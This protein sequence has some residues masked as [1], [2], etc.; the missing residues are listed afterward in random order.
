MHRTFIEENDGHVCLNS[1]PLLRRD[2]DEYSFGHEPGFWFL[3][4][5]EITFD[6]IPIN[7]IESSECLTRK[8]I[9]KSKEKKAAFDEANAAKFLYEL[10]SRTDAGKIMKIEE[11][12]KAR[13]L[14]DTGLGNGA[15]EI[16][17]ILMNGKELDSWLQ[18]Q[19]SLKRVR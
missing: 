17:E 6:F 14:K 4:M 15:K 5:D 16:I 11:R 2:A 18:R 3:N 9:S 19:K 13:V 12:M 8:H 10:K 1:G 7:Y